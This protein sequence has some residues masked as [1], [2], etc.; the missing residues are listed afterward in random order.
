VFDTPLCADQ[1]V[2]VLLGSLGEE[3]GV[4]ESCKVL[5]CG[6]EYV[7]RG[8][9]EESCDCKASEYSCSASGSTLECEDEGC[10]LTQ[11]YWKNHPEDW[12]VSSL[13]LGSVS[14]SAAELL[15]IL[16][17]PP[18]GNGALSLAHQLIAAKLNLASGASG[19]GVTSDIA[20]AD[21]LLGSL[22]LPPGG[23]GYLDPALTGALN[24][25][26]SGFNEGHTGPGHCDDQKQD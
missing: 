17:T 15:T 24:D 19:S 8:R 13:M 2:T 5:E 11:G 4:C 12:P 23:S 18:K 1:C 26:L 9:A 22:V 25:A 6:T 3:N 10:T 7:V 21:A 14:Y 20:A 16:K